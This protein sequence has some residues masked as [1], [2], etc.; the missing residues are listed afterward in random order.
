MSKQQIGVVGMAVMGRNRRST[1]KAVVIPS[2]FSTAPVIRPKKSSLRIQQK[3]VPFYTV[4]E[5]V[6]SLKHLV[7]SC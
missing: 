6:E 1:S 7:V 3:L 2:P 5:F 4:K